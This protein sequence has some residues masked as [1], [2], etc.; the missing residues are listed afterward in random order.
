VAANRTVDRSE[1]PGLEPV[2]HL[3]GTEDIRS[4]VEQ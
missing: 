3:V 4:R 2:A 1:P